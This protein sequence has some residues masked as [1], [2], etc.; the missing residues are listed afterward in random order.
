LKPLIVERG[1]DGSFQSG[2]SLIGLRFLSSWLDLVAR[3]VCEGGFRNAACLRGILS[4]KGLCRSFKVSWDTTALKIAEFHSLR[5][6]LKVVPRCKI[7][8]Q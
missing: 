3:C 4:S 7:H 8:D 2:V 6:H 5:E 1:C